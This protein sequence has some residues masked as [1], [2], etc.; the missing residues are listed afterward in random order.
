MTTIAIVGG[1]FSGTMAAVNLVR[2]SDHPVRVAIINSRRPLGRGTAYGTTRAEHLLN[3]AARNMSALPDMPSHFV[4]WLRSRHDFRSVPDVELREMFAPR[5]VYGDYVRGLLETCLHPIDARCQVTVSSI[6]DEAVDIAAS[7]SGLSVLLKDGTAVDAEQVV[8]ATGNQPPGSFP[9]TSPL[10]HDPRYRSDPWDDWLSRL[11]PPGG[12]VVLLGAGLTMVDIVLTLAEI[13]W[14]GEIVAVSRHGMLPKSHFRGIAYEDYLPADTDSLGLSGLRTI[15]QQHC[16]RLKQMSQN[17]AIA[18]D[19]LRPHTQRLW[20]N[21]STED[22]KEFL[23]HDA[24][25]WN[26]TRHRI[27][28]SIHNKVTDAL[29]AGRLKVVAGTIE[30]MVPGEQQID[31]VLRSGDGTELIQSGDLVINCTGPQSRFSQI[32][33]PLFDN[34][35]SKGIVNSDEL[36]LGIQVDDD[37]AVIDKD[38]NTS[39][40]L[41]AIGPLLKGSLWETTAVPE[42]RGQ[43]MRVAE[44]LLQREPAAVP[45]ADVIEYYI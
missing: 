7:D 30:S 44:V 15:V 43:A 22:K 5:R 12:K 45:E 33:L 37:F 11:P 24:A 23:K 29:D 1:G 39:S 19:K 25:A 8:L 20:R 10:R 2:L 28:V 42:L 31:V 34:L 6:D 16:E 9:A 32:G 40:G 36:D 35:L 26:V 14:D 4:D 27:A 21:L 18:I 3:V 13:G 17:S 38:G 41:Y